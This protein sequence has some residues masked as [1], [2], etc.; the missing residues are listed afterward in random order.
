MKKIPFSRI[1]SLVIGGLILGACLTTMAAVTLYRGV[2]VSNPNTG[3]A[4]LNPGAFRFDPVSGVP[5]SV[6]LSTFDSIVAASAAN[7]AYPCYLTFTASAVPVVGASGVVLGLPGYV[8][9]YDN[10]P[11]GHWSI[12]APAGVSSAVARGDVSVYAQAGRPGVLVSTVQQ[13]NCN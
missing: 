3:R 9:T 13:P 2:G 8:A 6:E 5:G 7:G 4:T 11:A 12:M 10:N 1:L